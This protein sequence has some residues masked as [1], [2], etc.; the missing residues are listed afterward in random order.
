MK[1]RTVGVGAALVMGSLVGSVLLISAFDS[2]AAPEA[3]A[4]KVSA[5][6][7]MSLALAD[8]SPKE[9]PAFRV[10]WQNVGD[11]DMTL[12]LGVMLTNGKVQLPTNLRFS[13]Q[14]GEGKARELQFAEPAIAGR[15]DDYVVPL[16]VGS[17]Y[18]VVLKWGDLWSPKSQEFRLKLPPGNSQIS[19][20]YRGGG[21]KMHNLDMQGVALLNF[22]Q[23]Q[24]S[25][26]I[27]AFQR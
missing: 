24:A 17:T 16:R 20:A 15:V 25:S 12:N 4:G 23:G 14:D 19:A 9:A 18:S 13:L 3:S 5:G 8:A 27:L 2:R 6:L 22:W 1:S 10:T 21:A 7:Q 11:T 26:N